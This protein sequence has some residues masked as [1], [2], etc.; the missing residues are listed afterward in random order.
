MVEIFISKYSIHEDNIV[1]VNSKDNSLIWLHSDKYDLKSISEKL[2]NGCNRINLS[3]FI[4]NNKKT[5]MGSVIKKFFKKKEIILVTRPKVTK[6]QE[7]INLYRK[8]GK[9]KEVIEAIKKSRKGHN[10]YGIN[11]EEWELLKKSYQ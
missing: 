11:K 9:E 1:L 8:K 3:S 7:I 6:K 5:I 4:I 10:Y 2:L